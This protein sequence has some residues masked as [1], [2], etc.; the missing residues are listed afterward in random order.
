MSTGRLYI[1]YYC[2]WSRRGG[3]KQVSVVGGVGP[4]GKGASA[5]CTS[6]L[7]QD[8]VIS[9]EFVISKAFHDVEWHRGSV[10]LFPRSLR[11]G[12]DMIF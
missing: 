3:Q 7:P 11:C 8:L 12:A 4:Q 1:N 2:G 9:K 5:F 6:L 10:F